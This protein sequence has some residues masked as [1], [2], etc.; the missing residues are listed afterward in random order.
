MRHEPTSPSDMTE[1]VP[2][3]QSNP[4]NLSVLETFF[5]FPVRISFADILRKYNLPRRKRTGFSFGTVGL[6]RYMAVTTMLPFDLIRVTA[7]LWN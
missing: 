2:Q 7:L 4:W 6:E 1:N 5:S 3:Y